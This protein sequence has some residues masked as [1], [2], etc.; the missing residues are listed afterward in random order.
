MMNARHVTA[1]PSFAIADAKARRTDAFMIFDHSGCSP[2]GRDSVLFDGVIDN[3]KANSTKQNTRQ[4]SKFK[5]NI[6][7]II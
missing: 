3:N 7:P 6:L 1:L 5:L 4:Q 2:A